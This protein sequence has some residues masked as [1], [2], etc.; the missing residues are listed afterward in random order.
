MKGSKFVASGRS[1]TGNSNAGA[2]P[3]NGPVF[4]ILDRTITEPPNKTMRRT[5]RP[6]LGAQVKYLQGDING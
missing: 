5:K 3:E 2:V 1:L 6:W 4:S